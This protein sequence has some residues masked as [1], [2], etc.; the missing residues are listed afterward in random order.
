MYFN[1]SK[2]ER[3]G[4][5]FLLT[6]ASVVLS[7]IGPLEASCKLLVKFYQLIMSQQFSSLEKSVCDGMI[8]PFRIPRLS[9]SGKHW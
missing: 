9:P 8:R 5:G 1:T 4:I 3:V 7:L 6:R 2:Y